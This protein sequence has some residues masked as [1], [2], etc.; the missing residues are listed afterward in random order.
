MV[1]KGQV[2]C[3]REPYLSYLLKQ[4]TMLR[5]QSSESLWVSDKFQLAKLSKRVLA[6]EILSIRSEI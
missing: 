5:S 2:K 6:L 1:C 4:M 3:Q